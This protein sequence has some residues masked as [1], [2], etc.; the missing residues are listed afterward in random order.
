[1]IGFNGTVPGHG[2]EQEYYGVLS[3]RLEAFIL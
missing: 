3:T 2:P 1:L